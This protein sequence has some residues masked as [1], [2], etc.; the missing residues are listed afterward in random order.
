MT[1]TKAQLKAYVQLQAACSRI[2]YRQRDFQV[3]S[4]RLNYEVLATVEGCGDDVACAKKALWQRTEIFYYIRRR[5]ITQDRYLSACTSLHAVLVMILSLFDGDKQLQ[6]QCLK[7]IYYPYP[8]VYMQDSDIDNS[9][10]AMTESIALI[11][12]E[13]MNGIVREI[14]TLNEL[15]HRWE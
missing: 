12:Q 3:A 15:L 8:T 2:A 7:L 14:D 9:D 6:E 13:V 1:R 10:L 11:D 4:A 5:D